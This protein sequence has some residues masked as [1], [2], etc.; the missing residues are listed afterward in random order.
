MKKTTPNL[1]T[2][3]ALLVVCFC[4]TL[5]FGQ[6]LYDSNGTIIWDATANSSHN[7]NVNFIGRDDNAG[8]NKKQNTDI[9]P[10]PMVLIG[11]GTIA[12]NNAA[13]PNTFATDLN[14]LVWGDNNG[15]MNDMDGELTI[16]F[17][18]GSGMTTVVDTP[19]RTWKII[20]NG[21]DIG[22]TRIAIPT[23]SLSGL[24]TLTTNDAYVLVIADDEAFSTNVETV[25][26]STSGANQIA[27]YDFDGVKF[28]T[29][30]VAKP[31]TGSRQINLD[32]SDD[33]IKFNN[34]NNLSGSFTMMFWIKPNGQNELSSDRS[35]ASKY[36]G[37]SGY[38]VYL[39][40]DNKINVVWNGGTL[41]TSNT[42]FPNG[43]WHNVTLTFSLN[44]LSLYIDGIL[45]R[46]ITTAVPTVDSN[47]FI[48]GA[49]Y[50]GKD[51]VRNY[52]K[53]EIDEFRLWNR[54]LGLTQLR[55]IMNQEILQ[56][57]ADT[58]GAIL[59]TN[60]SKNDISTVKWSS[61]VA[62]YTMNSFI[63]THIDDDSL[64]KNR[65]YLVSQS[66]ITVATQKAPIP[67]LS[68]ADGLWNSAATWS[69]DASID[70][71][72]SLSIV[73]NVTPIIWNIVKTNHNISSTAN[74]RVL[75][76]IVDTNTYSVANDT[77]VEI[78]HYLKLNG[79]IDLVGKSQLIQ[80]INSD[81]DPSS[82][83]TLERDQQGQSNKFNYNYWSSPVG[84]QNNSANNQGFT[85][86]NI[87]KDGTTATPQTLNWT[88]GV[89][90]TPT[91][92]ITLSKYWIF[93]F[94]D[95]ANGTAN[96]S[97][98]GNTG[99]VLPGQGF[100]LKG[101]G[102]AIANQNYTFVGKP[103]NGNITSSLLPNNL[104]LTGNPY[105]SAIDANKFIDDNASS[106]TGTLYFWEHYNTN[107]S[108]ASQEYQGGYATYTKLG[109]TAP[110]APTGI[111]GLG[112]SSKKPKRYIPV[113][114][115]FFVKGSATGGTI[116]YKNSQRS[117]IKE[118]SASSYTLFRSASP[119]ANSDNQ[120]DN[121][122]TE[123]PEELFMKIRLGYDSADQ[124]HRETLIGFMNQYGS[125]G[126]DNG[127]D[128]VSM[129]T[130]S[131]DMYFISG[132]YKLNILADGYF[133]TANTYPL[134]VK[135]ATPGNIKFSIDELE[136]IQE[137]FPIY[138]YD[139]VTN[140]YTNLREQAYKANLPAGT[141]ENRFSLRFSTGAALSTQDNLWNGLQIIHA[142]STQMVTIKND[143]LQVD[144][145]G[146]EL[147]N[148]LGQKIHTWSLENQSQEEINLKVNLTSSGTYLVKVITNKGSITKKIVF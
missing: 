112:S 70:A 100:T 49:E 131:N 6:N 106:I 79:K 39:S 3:F 12:A 125:T 141:F 47:N 76:L 117:F 138:L 89:N 60:I 51:D 13:N 28:F 46:S 123:V 122:D 81:L 113:G 2:N 86:S 85:L 32:G 64:N 105:P 121:G 41:L 17:N 102:A 142:Q 26:L 25:F 68:A 22:S 7:N 111:S 115:G 90:A 118:N 108:H 146:V 82:N 43:K 147:Y 97:Y 21:G 16:N 65:G 93:K 10:Q 114:Q 73:N 83:G 109:G 127:Y 18:G 94:Q 19:S 130:L 42:A 72:N 148:L 137:S 57:S 61:L 37:T 74:N 139:N 134:G 53:G 84:A 77:R 59:P 36:N 99:T 8:L 35:I 120:E 119:V 107:N 87:L 31:N 124:Y 67:Y 50:F 75:G 14:F 101:S 27:D 129:E 34:V 44:K 56:N 135:N 66:D 132:N 71:P 4:T 11:L 143:A 95:F 9:A 20:E 104:N 63:G 29:F 126:Y 103:N 55:F 69:G 52:F 116:T 48:I 128:G 136:N 58:K 24:P 30:G 80:V 110:V 23:S 40:N 145:N 92:P 15:D 133:N 38:R 91:S 62:Y 98:V 140:T 144:I 96:W 88:S 78:T 45:D 33:Y 54:A 1:R 5:S